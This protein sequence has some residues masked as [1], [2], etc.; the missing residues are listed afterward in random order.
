MVPQSLLQVDVVMTAYATAVADAK[1]RKVL[2]QVEWFRVVLEEAHWIRNQQSKLFETVCILHTSRR[3]CFTGA[4]V[5]N[6]LEDLVPLLKFL[7]FEPFS[8]TASFRHHIIIPL[9][10]E[11]NTNRFQPLQTL[12]WSVC[13][14]R[15]QN[16]L[17]TPAP[18]YREIRLLQSP[19]FYH[20]SEAQEA[21]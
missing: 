2:Q 11:E 10:D 6:R 7:R 20:D 1:L 12:L 15:M 4:P 8:E 3:W 5:Q 18:E 14:R 21:L 13:I 17:D 16:I 19:A 9:G